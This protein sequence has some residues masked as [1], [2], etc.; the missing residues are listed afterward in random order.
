ME[1]PERRHLCDVI[2]WIGIDRLL[3]ATD[4]PACALPRGRNLTWRPIWYG[5]TGDPHLQAASDNLTEPYQSPSLPQLRDWAQNQA[6]RSQYRAVGMYLGALGFGY[7]GPE[8]AKRHLAA[9]A[10]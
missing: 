8:L 3:L 2:G 10:C 9:P 7:N 4:Y 1:E 5:G 6:K